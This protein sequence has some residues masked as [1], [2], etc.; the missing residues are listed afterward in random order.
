MPKINGTDDPRIK[1]AVNYI[2]K[3]PDM[4]V[5]QA[6][7]LA[8]FSKMD[9]ADKAKRMWIRR[10]L[11]GKKGSIKPSLPNSSTT[12]LIQIASESPSL[13]PGS[14]TSPGG[15]IPKPRSTATAK[16]FIRRA[17]MKAKKKYDKVFKKA[18]LLYQAEKAKTKGLSASMVSDMMFNKYD[19]K[20]CNR[21]IQRYV[22][23]N[24]VGASPV[25]RGPQGNVKPVVYKNLCMAFESYLR[26][27]QINARQTQTVEGN[28]GRWKYSPHL[29]KMDR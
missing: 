5:P 15:I 19:I 17:K 1:E 18:T 14:T 2:S 21:K 29:S 13:R 7:K 27:N 6:M 28:I 4:K 22:K 16:Q 10:R 3:W 8:G 11:P 20:I 24:I 9:C 25:R 26:I 23:K 12:S